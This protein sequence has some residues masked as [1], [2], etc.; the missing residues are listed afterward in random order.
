VGQARKR[1]EI[2]AEI[3]A[4]LEAIGVQVYRMSA[5]GLPDLLTHDLRGRCCAMGCAWMPL[6]V[7]RPGGKLT[8]AQKETQRLAP[9]PIVDSVEQALGLFGVSL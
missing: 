1:D 7:K 2:E 4:A 3:V 5:K 9:F 6:E 8:V